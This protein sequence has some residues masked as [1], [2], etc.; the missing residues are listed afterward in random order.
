MLEPELIVYL[1]R[2]LNKILPDQG[3]AKINSSSPISEL[4]GGDFD[5]LVKIVAPVEREYDFFIPGDVLEKIITWQDLI[6]AMKTAIERSQGVRLVSF[7]TGERSS[8]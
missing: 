2:A 8:I 1:N 5:L 4:T 6:D 7:R 3:Q